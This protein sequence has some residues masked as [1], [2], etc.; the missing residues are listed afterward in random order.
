MVL[1]LQDG[2]ISPVICMK[3]NMLRLSSNISARD[4][5]KNAIVHKCDYEHDY[6]SKPHDLG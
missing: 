4:I 3:R 6:Q 5:V 2:C 1:V